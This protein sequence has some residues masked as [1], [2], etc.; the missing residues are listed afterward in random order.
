VA[1]TKS[2]RQRANAPGPALGVEVQ[3]Q[4]KP[5]QEAR[6]ARVREIQRTRLGGVDR[7]GLDMVPGESFERY[8]HIYDL[9]GCST[10]LH[11][12]SDPDTPDEA[13]QNV[14]GF[15]LVG[16]IDLDTGDLAKEPPPKI[17]RAAVSAAATMLEDGEVPF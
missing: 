6:A 11:T 17:D 14:R 12:T 5:T 7:I 4:S 1:T 16:V 8:A 13:Y 3:V 15:E 2:A 9:H 10:T